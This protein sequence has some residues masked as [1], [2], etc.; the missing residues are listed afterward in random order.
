[1][2]PE[3]QGLEVPR[4]QVQKHLNHPDS[5]RLRNNAQIF[6][7]FHIN[8]S[9]AIHMVDEK[10]KNTQQHT[11]YAW[12]VH[13]GKLHLMNTDTGSLVSENKAYLFLF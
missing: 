1:M 10:M 2:H 5:F 8:R 9:E 6:L 4:A 7:I 12:C 11:I 3:H 13:T